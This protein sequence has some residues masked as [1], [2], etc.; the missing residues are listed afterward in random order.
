MILIDT[1]IWI[2]HFKSPNERLVSLLSDNQVAIHEFIIG[3]LAC[4]QLKFREEILE[5]LQ[6][7]PLLPTLSHEEV[8]YMINKRKLYGSGIGWVDAHLVAST[9]VTKNHVWSYDKSLI[10]IT[11]KLNISL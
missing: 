7:L 4:G 6:T 3:E 9:L 8:L 1:S 2:R 10:N 11:E 5:L